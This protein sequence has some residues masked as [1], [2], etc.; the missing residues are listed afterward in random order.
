MGEEVSKCLCSSCRVELSSRTVTLLSEP[1]QLFQE[2]R[3]S[4]LI[5]QM[6]LLRLGELQEQKSQKA[7]T[8]TI[9]PPI[10]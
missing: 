2:G 8:Q 1:T 10:H 5:L 7:K 9:R 3:M 6:E 4:I